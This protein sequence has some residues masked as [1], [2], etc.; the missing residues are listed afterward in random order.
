MRILSIGNSFSQDAHKWLHP[1]AAAG[2]DNIDTY[3]LYIG[4]CTLE[5][6][7]ECIENDLNEYE[8]QGNGGEVIGKSSVLQALKD[9]KYD[10]VTLQQA[11]GFSG[12]PQ[13]YIPYLTE[14][15]DYVRKYQPDAK[16]YFHQT[17]S[18]E[19]D[20]DHPHFIFYNNDQKEMYRRICDS[21]QMASRIIGAEIIPVGD[22]IQSLRENAKEFDY[23]GGGLSLCRDGYHLSLLY[24]RFAAA[25]VWYKTLTGKNS[26]IEVFAEQNPEFDIALLRI[27]A[28]YI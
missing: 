3:N 25:A 16:L 1:L 24:G 11:S 28:G 23:T 2:N 12:R 20:S 13:S 6:H 17:W 10:A 14:T 15:A 19:I 8:K 22:A 18:Y 7:S 5:K 26:D 27:I 4:G 21:A 9:G